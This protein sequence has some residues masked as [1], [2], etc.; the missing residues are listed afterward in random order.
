VAADT[1]MDTEPEVVDG[2]GD[3]ATYQQDVFL[4]GPDLENRIAV[5]A[6]TDVIVITNLEERVIPKEPLIEL[7]R[8]V[9]ERVGAS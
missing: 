1:F 2:L 3:A 9:V 5:L 4:S 6:G 8:L 7:T